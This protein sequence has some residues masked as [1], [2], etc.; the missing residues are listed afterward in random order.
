MEALRGAAAPGRIVV[1]VWARPGAMALAVAMALGLSACGGGGGG[2]GSSG[3]V[4][5]TPP[6][7]PS[8]NPPT[9]S[10]G[11]NGG[12]INVD[13]NKNTVLPDNISGSINLIK[14][15]AGALTLTGTSTYSGGTTINQGNLQIGNGGTTGSI[16][17]NITNN[18][19]LVFNRS[20]DVSFDGIVSGS[21]GLTKAGT[22]A[23]TLAGANSYSGATQLDTGALYVDGDQSAA[24]GATIVANGATLGGHGTLGGDV[25]MADGATLSPGDRGDIGTLTINGNLKLSAGSVLNFGFGQASGGSQPGDLVNIKGN[26]TLD[27]LLNVDAAS[28]G[29]PGPGV[30]RLFNYDG[31]LV[32]NGL[33]LASMPSPGWTV[34]TGVA[35]Q[36]NL[37]DTQGMVFSFWDGAAGPKGNNAIDGG[38]GVWESGGASNNWTDASGAVNAPFSD[39]SFAVFQNMPGT[40]TVSSRN[41]T[42]NAQGMQFASYG[43]VLQGDS[44]HLIGS[45][46]HP[47]QSI[48]RVG[49]GTAA[50]ARYRADINNVL[51]GSTNLVKTDTGTLALSGSNTYTGGTTIS[52]GTLQ[53][54]NG[55][56]GGSILGDVTNNASL[57]FNRSDNIVFNGIVSG[58]G[59]LVQLGPGQLTLTGTNTYTGGTTVKAGTLELPAGAALG[60]GDIIVGDTRALF[61]SAIFRVNQ[62]AAPSNRIMLEARATLDNAGALGN[63]L[64]VA[65]SGS[66]PYSISPTL[67]N[68]D[69]GSIRGSHAGIAFTQATPTIKN[70]SGG[71]IEGGDFAADLGFGGTVSNDGAGSTIRSSGGI[72]VQ[73]TGLSSSIL[74][75]AGGTIF[76]GAAAINLRYGGIVTNDGAGSSIS[77]SNGIAVK[78]SGESA[79]IKNSGGATISGATTALY[80]QHG[81]SVINSAGSTIAT[82]GTTTGDCAGAG[83]CAIF[84]ASDSNT[85]QSIGGALSLTNEGT[86]IGN[87]QLVATAN[88]SAWLASG[89]SIHGDL[90]LGSRRDSFLTLFSTPGTTQSYAQAVTGKTT[91][92]GGMTVIGGGTWVIDNDDLTPGSVT[93]SGASLQI[94]TGGTMG[95]IGLDSNV[96]VYRGKLVFNR[97]DNVTYAGS[98]SSMNSEA[99]DGTLVQAGTGTLT[100]TNHDISPT[101]IEIRSGTLQ[102]DNTGNQPPASLSSFYFSS[103]VLNNGALVFDSS[104]AIFGGTVTGTGSVTQNGSSALILQGHNTYTGGTTIN[105]G[106]IR[107]MFALPGDVTV[108]PAG[109]LDGWAGGSITTLPGVAGHLFNAGKVAVHNGDA[110]TGGNYTQ[111][112]TGTLAVNLG[113]KLAV[114][115]TATLNGGTLEITGA[116]PGYVSNTHTQVLTATGGLTGTFGQLVKDTGVV[117]TSTTVNYDANSAWLDTTGL[118]VTTAAAGNGVSYTPASFGSAQRVQG[119]FTQLDSKIAAGH[120]SEVSSDFVHAAGE[121]QQAPTLQAAQASLQSLSGQLHAASAAMTFESIDASSRALADHFDD[122]LGGST[123]SGMWTRNLNVGGGMARAGYDG[124]GFQL[125]GWLVGSDRKI[126][127]SGVAGYAFGQSQGQQRLDQAYDRNRSRSTEGMLYAGWVNGNWY[128]QGRVGFGHFQQNV[129]RRLLLGTSLQSVSTD[130]SGNYNVAYGETGLRLNW[131]GTRITPF[132]NAEYASIDRDGFAERGAGGFGLRTNAQ[133]LDRWRAGLGLRAARHWDFAGGRTLDLSA[134]MQFRR[135]LAAQ[136]DAFGASFVGL[137]QW[138]P[139]VGIGLSRYSGVLNVGLDAKLSARTSLKLGYDYEQG[140]RDQAQTLSTNLIM[141]F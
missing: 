59:S 135:T 94:G 12:Q 110:Q 96:A 51:D 56:T 115:G 103:P 81:G 47:T 19:L 72:A 20:D 13:A 108:N 11:F 118:N 128:T 73:M 38:S 1:G 29:N 64:T 66:D 5:P 78:V 62:G 55:G 52:Q 89:S 65:V 54:G 121:F 68:H 129:N 7:T 57:A 18:A 50:G 95:S 2:G 91:F 28:G 53:I 111:A 44:I 107:T 4:R 131:A 26:L 104:F 116:D 42:V 125:N 101:R 122:L 25:I 22:G 24:K 23:L 75:T 141:A 21:G 71:I 60:T 76:G 139:L 109:T 88:N 63:N 77:S 123:G 137:Q 9:G 93:I 102:V 84:A 112:P 90:Y 114:A 100:L 130:Y 133:T 138:Q 17:G 126:G 97:S 31:T 140:Q 105:N 8:T 45:A 119:A 46:D 35:H 134:S 74:N 58:G 79:G 27:G 32:D 87:V 80:L 99:Y 69:G 40:V 106:S 85:T 41:G 117:F 39:S 48:I 113:S 14:S 83:S 92:V 3:N 132:A 70:R 82:T 49:D 136:G 10:T 16:T 6:T 86:I 34:Q 43:Y 124:I 36:V 61:G 127:A 98:I 37:I 30:H 33:S 15:G 67:L 120:L